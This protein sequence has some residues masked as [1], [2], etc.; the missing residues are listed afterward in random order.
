V[1]LDADGQAG[2]F[3]SRMAGPLRRGLGRGGSGEEQVSG[4]RTA[5]GSSVSHTDAR[6]GGCV[7]T[8]TLADNDGATN[9]SSSSHAN[10]PRS[11]RLRAQPA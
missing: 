11:S 10:Q 8:L 3:E 4:E 7:V 6:A 5:A 1:A 2:G 9:S